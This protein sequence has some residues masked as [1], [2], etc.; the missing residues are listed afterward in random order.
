MDV[1]RPPPPAL[2]VLCGPAGPA[3]AERWC[4]H[5]RA[6]L[7]DGTC[8]V[9]LLDV[10][11]LSGSATDVIDTL[12][13]LQLAARRCGGSLR[14]RRTRPSLSELL[15]HLGLDG[16]LPPAGPDCPPES[17]GPT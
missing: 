5:V 8:R 3:A 1:D 7:A 14:L 17:P 10:Q 4:A 13:R 6:L 16:T 12:A 11:L 2:L 9:V 15:V